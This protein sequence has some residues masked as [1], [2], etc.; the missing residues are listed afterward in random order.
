KRGVLVGRGDDRGGS[1][2]TGNV[3]DG[4]IL[5]DNQVGVTISVALST[6]SLS[7]SNDTFPRWG[8]AIGKYRSIGHFLLPVESIRLR[9]RPIDRGRGLAAYRAS[10][11]RGRGSSTPTEKTPPPHAT[12]APARP[13][14]AVRPGRPDGL[15]L[16]ATPGEGPGDGVFAALRCVLRT[17]P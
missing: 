7:L 5:T 16:P 3:T 11:A 6:S 13:P 4:P 10:I 17:G 2:G 15:P 8:L 9:R 14:P 12:V 1:P